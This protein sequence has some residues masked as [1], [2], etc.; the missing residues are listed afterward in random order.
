MRIF[1]RR[2]RRSLPM[3]LSI[4]ICNIL[5]KIVVFIVKELYAT[6]VWLINYIHFRKID[7]SYFQI[8]KMINTMSPRQFELFCAEL[9]RV[10]G[11]DTELTQATCD[12]GKD[13]IIDGN[14]FVECK[15]YSEHNYIG[16]EICQKLEG[17]M[18]GE[19]IELGM[20]ITTGKIHKNAIEYIN[21]VR[22]I[23]ILDFDDIM[24]MIKK[25]EVK[26]IPVIF[27]NVYGNQLLQ[28]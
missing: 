15:H 7:Y 26:K 5:V 27:S 22:N 23:E 9:F 6:I 14:I 12:G 10:N 18:V 25:T 19:G 24:T 28:M 8:K 11:F 16:R 20:I 13:I 1:R 4:F 3:V 17:A 2:G 21:K